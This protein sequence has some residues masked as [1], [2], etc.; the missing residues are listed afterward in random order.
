MSVGC[1]LGLHDWDNCK[2]LSCGK[3][4]D[5]RH[6]WDGCKCSVCGHIR[7]DH[8]KWDFLQDCNNCIACGKSHSSDN[9]SWSYGKC[10]KCGKQI[11]NDMKLSISIKMNNLFSEMEKFYFACRDCNNSWPNERM[12]EY[13]ISLS[14]IINCQNEARRM[15][16]EK[17]SDIYC[18][19]CGSHRI[20]NIC[21]SDYNDIKNGRQPCGCYNSWCFLYKLKIRV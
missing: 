6:R 16:N 19:K 17:L 9:H 5:D 3:I 2:C 21:E 4:R 7:D 11:Q 20:I 18:S 12:K 1:I 14:S 15:E 10:T 8:H 13:L